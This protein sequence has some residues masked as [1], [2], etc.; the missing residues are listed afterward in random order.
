MY[1]TE[2]EEIQEPQTEICNKCMNETYIVNR[3][4]QLCQNCNFHRIHGISYFDHQ[5]AK[6]TEY[7]KK[8][9]ERHK[10]KKQIQPTNTKQKTYNAATGEKKPAKL[11][12][13][14]KKGKETYKTMLA[15]KKELRESA[16]NEDS[17]FCAG[18]LKTNIQLD[19]SHI[20][21]VAQRPDLQH[22]KENI[23]LMCRKCHEKHESG[24]VEKMTSLACF[25]HDIEYIYKN[26][27]TKFNKILFKIADYL[28]NTKNK[29]I[30]YILSKIERFD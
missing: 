3:T 22:E 7:R 13:F 18:C 11:P 27:E 21:S 6:Q 1:N 30:E 25:M 17:Y 16:Q 19:C 12:F 14:S 10:A 29:R 20:I 15:V 2:T 28:Q 26:D 4:H 23:S 9:Q 8:Q 5:K 24:D